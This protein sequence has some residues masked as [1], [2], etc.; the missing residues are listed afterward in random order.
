MGVSSHQ[1]VALQTATD[2]QQKHWNE[3]LC[4]CAKADAILQGHHDLDVRQELL[5][6]IFPKIQDFHL[7][8]GV[9]DL[10]SN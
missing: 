5:K 6:R 8:E 1:V 4:T 9:V 2:E 7:C 10:Q 3:R